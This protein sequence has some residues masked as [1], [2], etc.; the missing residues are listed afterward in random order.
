MTDRE[1]IPGDA[2]VVDE[3]EIVEHA[4]ETSPEPAVA[5]D[6]ASDDA[7]TEALDGVEPPAPSPEGEV[8]AGQSAG[9]AAAA[10]VEDEPE[11]ETAVEPVAGTNPVVQ[12]ERA[13]EPEP[14][15]EF[16]PEP[17]PELAPEPEPEPAPDLE[18]EPKPTRADDAEPVV[19]HE[20][21]AEPAAADDV[22]PEPEPEPE[23]EPEAEPEPEPVAEPQVEARGAVDRPERSANDA[24]S[25]AAA[26]LAMAWPPQMW[27][28]APVEPATEA[29]TEL[30]DTDATDAEPNEASTPGSATDAK[31]EADVPSLDPESP[32]TTGE[33]VDGTAVEAVPAPSD[34]PAADTQEGAPEP[35]AAIAESTPVPSPSVPPVAASTDAGGDGQVEPSTQDAPQDWRA[36]RWSRRAGG[37]AVALVVLLGAYV[38]AAWAMADRV[39]VG[40]VVAGVEIGGLDSDDAV[41]HLDDALADITVEPIPVV[42]GE[43]RTEV[44]PATLGLTFDASATV[45]RLT[46]FGLQPAKMWRHVFGGGDAEPVTDIDTPVLTAA[47]KGVAESL[48]MSPVDGTV[49]FLEGSVETTDAVDGVA[50]DVAGAQDLLAREWLTAPRPVVLPTTVVT[51]DIDQDAVDRAIADL[52]LPVAGAPVSVEVADQV[53]EI[54]ASVL[55]DV[56]RFEPDGSDLRVVMDGPALVDAVVARTTG[57]LTAPANAEF[58]FDD[59]APVI[60]PGVPGTTLDPDALATSVTA[61]AMG[62]D[63]IAQV[64]LVEADPADSAAA[65]QALGITEVVSEFST[66]LTSEPRRTKNITVGAAAIS[67]TLVRPGETFSLTDAL[68]PIDADHGF[69]QAGAI[70]NGEHSDAW[71]GGLSQVS[72]TTYNAAYFAGFVDVEH[73]PHSEWFSRYPE[74][75]EA[76]IFTGSLD[77]RWE[78]NTP[79]GALVQAWIQDG[80]VNVR[81]WGTKY[82]TV[83]STTGGRSNVVS[84]TTVYSQS[85]TCSSQRRGNSGFTV[86]VRR[87]VSREGTVEAD[88]SWTTRYRPQNAIVCG[89]AP[90]STPTPTP[91]PTE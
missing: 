63:R 7:P 36:R 8:E 64:E 78:N 67:G 29:A 53:A 27:E 25:A 28:P 66:P 75:R 30:A 49:S 34:G 42:A 17:E 81:I 41:A 43:Q 57:L 37:I 62:D 6:G 90:S 76:T 18:P 50:V 11:V 84:P 9:P 52:A 73:H 86:T 47:V 51:P 65:L 44:E 72:T 14:E 88:E 15:P 60:V 82:W 54:P 69:V 71:G 22:E 32:E 55:M 35:S 19:G 85:A 83:E 87:V 45:D 16:E 20:P 58:T 79:Y 2:P 12:V 33:S 61:A 21:S 46:G 89:A 68:G 56:S 5:P 59:G 48:D 4:E 74:G 13:R 26:A 77:M 3:S 10:D 24:S 40:T 1:E 80:R 91:A 38:A 31:S 39:P 70:I 23:H